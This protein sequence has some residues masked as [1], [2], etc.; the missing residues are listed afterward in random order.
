MRQ[1][2]LLVISGKYDLS[3]DLGETE[4][5]REDV[6]DAQVHTLDAGHFALARPRIRSPFGPGFFRL[7]ALENSVGEAVRRLRSSP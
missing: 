2:Q 1:T 5:Y 6:P 4:R 7:V 3:F